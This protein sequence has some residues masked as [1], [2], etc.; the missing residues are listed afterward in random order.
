M[1][2][3]QNESDMSLNHPRLAPRYR[4][5]CSANPGADSLQTSLKGGFPKNPA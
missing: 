3:H 5:V 4:S 1:A 2:F